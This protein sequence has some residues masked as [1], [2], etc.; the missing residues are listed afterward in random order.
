MKAFKRTLSKFS[1][2]LKIE[3]PLYI[4]PESLTTDCLFLLPHAAL[5][6]RNHIMEPIGQRW[7]LE[8]NKNNYLIRNKKSISFFKYGSPLVVP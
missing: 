1:K 4:S 8:A 3:D 2:L 7:N 6:E 5:I